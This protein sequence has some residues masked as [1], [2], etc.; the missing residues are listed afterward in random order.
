VPPGGKAASF[1]NQ[2]AG[3]TNIPATFKGV[4]RA[5]SSSPFTIVG[6]RG[7]Y[8]ERG[9][10]LIT[11]TT[12]TSETEHP[13]SAE[14]VFPHFA[15]GG[16]YST[17][18]ILISGSGSEGGTI[19]LIDQSGNP[20]NVTISQPQQADIF[21]GPFSATF[22]SYLTTDQSCR[23]TPTIAGTM[24]LELTT[25][26]DGTVSGSALL[27]SSV[28]ASASPSDCTFFGASPVPQGQVSGTSQ[29][30]TGTFTDTGA[31]PYTILFTG[32]RSGDTINATM[33]IT[34]V[35]ATVD[36]T[37]AESGFTQL[38]VSISNVVLQKQ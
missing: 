34:R 24:R 36:S 6:L 9:D 35:F 13:T 22:P 14:V 17:Q 32:R 3:F 23:F 1:L 28:T 29:S 4:L 27:H 2:I 10:F 18:L 19:R 30:I 11:T 8:N 16:G 38:S 33:G 26:A 25:S 15:V 5:S 12:P 37:G 7:R 20:M 31:R 21:E